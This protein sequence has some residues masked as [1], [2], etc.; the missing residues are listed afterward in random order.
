MRTPIAHALAYP[1]RID[2]GV[3]DARPR[4]A[5]VARRSRRRISTAFR[6]SRLAYDA[7]AAGGTAPVVL[8]AANEIAVAA[9]LAGRIRFTDIAA[10]AQRALERTPRRALVASLDD[11]LATADARGAA[12]HA[13]AASARRAAPVRRGT[14]SPHDRAWR[15]QGRRL[16]GRRSACS[17]C[18]TSSA[19]TWS[20]AGAASRC[21]ASP[22]A[23][24]ACCGR[25]ASDATGPSGPLSAIPLGGYV[26]MADERE[27]DVAPRRRCRARSTAQSV[28]KRIAIVAAGPIANLLLAVAAVRGNVHG[29]HSRA[30]AR[31]SR[32][33]P[34]ARRR[35]AAGIRAGDLVVAIDG[36]AGR[37]L[38]GP[39]LAPAARRQGRDDIARRRS[40]AS[41]GGDPA[42]RIV[43]HRG[44]R[45]PADWEG[46]RSCRSSALRA[47]FGRAA[48]RRGARRQAGGARGPQARRS[49]RRDRRRTGAL[50]GGRRRDHQREARAPTV[51]SRIERERRD[52]RRAPSITEVAGAGRAHASA[53]PASAQG[54]SGGRGTLWRSTVRYGAVR[55][56]RRRARARRGSC[57]SSRSRCSGRILTGEASLKN[58]SGPIT[59]A[60]FAGQSAQAGVLVFV[61]YL[62][63]ISISLGVL[64]LLPVPLLDGGHLLYYFAEIF[65]G[66]PRLGPRLRG[67]PAHRHGHARRAD[68]PGALQ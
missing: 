18:S 28:W 48:D 43:R 16:P 9:F 58:I 6:A 35:R 66:S 46:N 26:K 14:V 20:R 21:C 8:N 39:A 54:R 10:P 19:I 57:R 60:D 25:A 33:R 53:S 63:L 13:R 51:V 30:E 15:L 7:L 59:L 68:G 2:A 62:A 5:R 3:A 12:A 36:D 64:N 40:D 11:A 52:A 31:S 17:S 42:T 37:E 49:H 23:S 44:A 24:A 65:K 61:G 47:D 1:E 38:A 55:S 67:R 4:R 27:G 22:S 56:A 34:Q 41:D 29:G 50:A 32:R 45:R